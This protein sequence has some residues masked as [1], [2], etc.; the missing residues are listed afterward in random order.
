MS[1]AI[2]TC[3]RHEP[4]FEG[5]RRPTPLGT[6]PPPGCDA[7]SGGAGIAARRSSVTPGPPGAPR[8]ALLASRESY[9]VLHDDHS[10]PIRLTDLEAV[11]VVPLELS[12]KDLPAL[13]RDGHRHRQVG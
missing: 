11:P 13:Q 7:T 5:V 3:L 2:V 4:A 10:A 6:S 12:P 8:H 9:G 1:H